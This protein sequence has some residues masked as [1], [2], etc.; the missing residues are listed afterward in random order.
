MKS[1]RPIKKQPWFEQILPVFEFVQNQ[2]KT[3]GTVC[4]KKIIAGAAFN[5]AWKKSISDFLDRFAGG[6][7]T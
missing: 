2:P 1:L 3:R 5:S 4:A 6:G 7:V